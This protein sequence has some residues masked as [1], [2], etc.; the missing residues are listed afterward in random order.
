MIAPLC[1]DVVP[2]RSIASDFA[3]RSGGSRWRTRRIPR[4][5]PSGTERRWSIIAALAALADATA[6]GRNL[7][8]LNQVWTRC[9]QSVIGSRF[10]GL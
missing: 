5:T 1:G 4:P 9:T 10:L 6:P 8:W 3:A 2:A 7:V